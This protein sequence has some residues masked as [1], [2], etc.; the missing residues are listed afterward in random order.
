[1]QLRENVEISRITEHAEKFSLKNF[2]RRIKEVLRKEKI[3]FR[4]SLDKVQR[5]I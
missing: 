2:R 1:M 5:I 4:L 3:Y